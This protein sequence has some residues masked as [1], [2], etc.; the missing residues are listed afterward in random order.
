[1]SRATFIEGE[2]VNLENIEEDDVEF[3]RDNI[4]NPDVRKY[5]TARKP[6][7]LNQEHGFFEEVISRDEDVNLAIVSN[8]E[9]VGIISLEEDEK[10]IRVAE[11]GIWIDTEHH[12]NGYGTE[13]AELI[14]EYGFNELNYHKILARA[15]EENQGSNKIWKRL[16]FTHEGTLREQIFTEGEF[17]DANI[18][19]ILENEWRNQ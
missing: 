17:V 9:I 13:A 6:I 4:N 18:Y 2:K 5:L 8:N 1:M 19:G 10:E 15:Y 16:G 14:T 3:L 12:K 7:N 11:I